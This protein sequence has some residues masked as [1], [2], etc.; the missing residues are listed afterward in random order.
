MDGSAWSGAGLAGRGLSTHL[1][2]EE[3]R[4]HPGGPGLHFQ[5]CVRSRCQLTLRGAKVGLG[6]EKSLPAAR[7]VQR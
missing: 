7:A 3:I 4:G 1:L 2:T 6:V 5:L